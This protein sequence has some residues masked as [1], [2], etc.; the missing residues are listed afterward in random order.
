[1]AEPLLLGDHPSGGVLVF[2]YVY[3]ALLNRLLLPVLGLLL[4]VAWLRHD[5]KTYLTLGFACA[6]LAGLYGNVIFP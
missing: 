1:M 5:N 2:V 6:V 4:V 3:V